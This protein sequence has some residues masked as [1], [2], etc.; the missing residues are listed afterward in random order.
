MRATFHN[1]AGP[2]PFFLRTKFA[3]LVALYVSITPGI[4]HA[5]I[6]P[7]GGV[8]AVGAF[9]ALLGTIIFMIIGFLW[10]PI[11]RIRR[12]LLSKRTDRRLAPTQSP[13]PTSGAAQE[14]QG[15]H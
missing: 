5:Y 13:A 3:S 15:D 8:S 6:G 9:I 4:A 11:K 1:F 7:G 12:A 10:Y 14:G 2:R